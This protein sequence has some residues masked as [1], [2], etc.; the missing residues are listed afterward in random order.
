[1]V[2]AAPAEE[3]A[4]ARGLKAA[5]HAVA[6]RHA[7]DPIAGRDDGPDVLVPDREAGFDLHATVVDVQVRAANAGRLDP[8]D[9]VFGIDRLGLGALLD[10]H[11]ARAPGR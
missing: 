6:D 4:A 5:E 10:A 3:A 9:R 7:R 11:D 2:E 1:M 8:H